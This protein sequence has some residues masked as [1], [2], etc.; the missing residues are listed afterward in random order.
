MKPNC[1]QASCTF[2]F[3]GQIFSADL[4]HEEKSYKKV[5]TN[6]IFTN[7]CKPKYRIVLEY[8]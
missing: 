2:K 7:F 6:K 4:V 5:N 8:E 1:L 3:N